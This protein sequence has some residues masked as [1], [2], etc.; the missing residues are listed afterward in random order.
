MSCLLICE[1]I[2]DP[3]HV[4]ISA[5]DLPQQTVKP[6]NQDDTPEKY[7]IVRNNEYVRVKYIF[8]YC[9]KLKSLQSPNRLQQYIR[10]NKFFVMVLSYC[11]LL[12]SISM[13]N[14]KA[15][16]KY[17]KISYRK[18]STYLTGDATSNMHD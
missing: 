5:K 13:F 18:L 15:F 3:N 9:D 4:S 10:N 16:Q 12:L 14:S 1:T 7:F 17:V 6:K 11:I 2:C 8:L